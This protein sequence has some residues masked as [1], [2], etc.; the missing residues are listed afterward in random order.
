M[1]RN[2]VPKGYDASGIASPTPVMKIALSV[3]NRRVCQPLR[4]YSKNIA[5]SQEII[6]VESCVKLH[7]TNNLSSSI[8]ALVD[9]SALLDFSIVFHT[10]SCMLNSI[11]ALF[12]YF[13][14]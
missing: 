6:V 14:L 13:Y 8:G 9:G 11:L 4:A 7:P 2:I 3:E 1:R 5:I 12:N 10:E